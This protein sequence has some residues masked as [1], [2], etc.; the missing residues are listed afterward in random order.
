ME[1][2]AIETKTVTDLAE[3]TSPADTDLFM[4]GDAGTAT[5]KKVKWSSMLAA[6]KTKI[7][8]WNFGVLETMDKTITGAINSLV[9]AVNEKAQTNHASTES[10]YGLGSES[11]YGHVKV[12]NDLT[13]ESHS[14]GTA[15]SAYQGK[16]LK[17]NLDK[18]VENSNIKNNLTT[19]EPGKVL[20]A[21]QGKVLN[22]KF[23]N[24]LPKSGGTITGA[25]T[26]NGLLT[27]KDQIRIEY[28]KA[29]SWASNGPRIYCSASQQM[30][31]MASNDETYALH[32]GVHD[33]VWALNPDVSGNLTLGTGNHKWGAV[34]STTGT[35][36]TSD[37][38]LKRNIEELNEKHVA[39]FELLKPC[40]FEFVDGTSGRRHIGF[41]SQD[42]EDAMSACGLSDLDFAGFCKD[43]KT[44][45]VK[46]TMEVEVVNLE[47]EEVEIQ[48]IVVV[49]DEPVEGEY[50]Y[51]LRYDEF[52]AL[53]TAMIQYLMKRMDRIE[54]KLSMEP[55]D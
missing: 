19:T 48:T 30:F 31:L 38:N 1:N 24:Y 17:D 2:N 43:Q 44:V 5:L 49:E 47:T 9:T 14:D 15:L 16:I 28:N 26:V 54:K 45:P 50:V 23:S 29:I 25:A 55:I 46:K 7:A 11:N 36:Q 4:A 40:S 27:L 20:D 51:S 22:D 3:K 35:I 32:L 37:R 12:I 34:Y 52:V 18:K 6:I 8:E 41:V 53:N 13:Q 21:R 10:T 33:G 39:F 42:V